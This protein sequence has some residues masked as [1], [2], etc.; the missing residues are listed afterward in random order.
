MFLRVFLLALVFSLAASAQTVSVPEKVEISPGRLASITIR[1]DGDDLRWIASPELDVFREYDPD[2][3]VVRLRVIAYAEGTYKLVAITCKGGKLSEF[4]SCVVVVG[5]PGPGPG[6]GPNPPTPPTP[7]DDPFLRTLQVAYAADSGTAADKTLWRVSLRGVYK[8][9]SELDLSRVK[10]AGELFQV[11]RSSA[12]AVIPDDNSLFN[13]RSAI[14]E[15]IKQQ[16]PS[17]PSAELTDDHKK[18]ATALFSRLA[19]LLEHVK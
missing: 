6:P 12:K 5:K 7:P 10:T 14:S 17:A 11:L 3:K 9:A 4:A 15:L 1:W 18:K 2:A 8:S 19:L 16:L 13:V